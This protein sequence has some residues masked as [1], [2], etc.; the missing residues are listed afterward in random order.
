MH[1][2][3]PVLLMTLSVLIAITLSWFA[4]STVTGQDNPSSVETPSP[5]LTPSDIITYTA[6]LPVLIV[7][8]RTYLPMVAQ[9]PFLDEPYPPDA[10]IDKS[11]NVYLAWKVL[12]GAFHVPTTFTVYLEANNPSPR[13]IITDSLTVPA[14]DPETLA[15]NTQYY[16]KVVATDANGRQV[17]S[18]TWAFHT[19]AKPNPPDL[20]AMVEVPA[21]PFLMG[22]DLSNPHETYCSYNVWHQ[23]EPV[24]SIYLDAF[25]IDKYE[26]TNS[27]YRA[28]ME[29]GACDPPWMT[30][31]VNN[32]DLDLHP[33]T[34][35]SWWSAQ[36]FCTWEGKRLPTEA[37][38]E[39][40]ARGPI[41]TRR[42]PWGNEEPDCLRT[43]STL[44]R[45]GRDCNLLPKGTVP[46]GRYP[47]GATPYGA[48]D[49]TGNVFEWVNDKYDV[50]YYNYAP[51]INPPGPPTSRTYRTSGELDA[52]LPYE[53]LGFPIFTL[54][55]GPWQGHAHYMRVS[56]R[57]FGHHGP[58]NYAIYADAP[59]FRNNRTGFRCAR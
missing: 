31:L 43:N 9:P 45:A 49:M 55:D 19:E 41:D 22:C 5:T 27:E 48:Y 35:I 52:P 59:Y 44:Y 8:H 38:W 7:P 39:K 47:R 32:P 10:S 57:H 42:W 58:I 4:G 36:D 54:R 2:T 16:W 17:E 14:F 11:L 12:N 24:R 26:V 30:L 3:K 40:A 37:E 56:H 20:D 50:N 51:D 53:E 25:E 34:F 46:V 13:T 1:S 23:D 15:E 21:G 29:A 33:V 6:Y 18:D 28:C